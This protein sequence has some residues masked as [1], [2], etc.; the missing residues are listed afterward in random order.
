[1][2]WWQLISFIDGLPLRREEK[3]PV[4]NTLSLPTILQGVLLGTP[5]PPIIN[6]QCDFND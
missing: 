6:L 3:N 2:G 4:S 5:N 1:M